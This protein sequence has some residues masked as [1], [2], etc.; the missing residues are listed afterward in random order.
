MV[1]SRT[2]V[3]ELLKSFNGKAFTIH[4]IKKNGKRRS[5]NGRLGVT[6]GVKGV[7]PSDQMSKH[8]VVYD[9]QN[10]GFRKVDLETVEFVLGKG[11][12]FYVES[13]T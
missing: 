2:R 5:L 4:F 10:R 3:S 8:M 12:I 7:R 13:S 11:E 1:V 6:K 9:L